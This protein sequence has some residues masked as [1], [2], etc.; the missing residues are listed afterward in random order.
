MR[1]DMPQVITERSRSGHDRHYHELRHAR[2][3]YGRELED[4]PTHEGMR[5]PFRQRGFAKQFGEHLS[6]LRRFLEKQVGR[7]WNAVHA[8]ICKGLHANSTLHVHVRSHVRDFVETDICILEDGTYAW[9]ACGR[10]IPITRGGRWHHLIVCPRSGL[11][12]RAADLPQVRQHKAE[13]EAK[14]NSE[15]AANPPPIRL[16]PETDL[17]RINGIWYLVTYATLPEPSPMRVKTIGP[18]DADPDPAEMKKVGRWLKDLGEGRRAVMQL[19]HIHHF[20]V[21]VGR[22]IRRGEM[23]PIRGAVSKSGYTP[24]APAAHYAASKRQAPHAL[25]LKHGLRNRETS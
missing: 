10:A 14:K 4:R 21:V 17:Q 19:V 16:D 1:E 12:L 20:D 3:R 22:N 24:T 23:A 5:R 15:S 11:L 13:Q 6:P 7:P 18:G 9:N 8:E 25:L 2:S